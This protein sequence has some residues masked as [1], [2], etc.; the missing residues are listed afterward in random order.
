MVFF[1]ENW[2]QITTLRGEKNVKPPFV[3]NRFQ[4][5][6]LH[7]LCKGNSKISVFPFSPLAKFNQALLWRITELTISQISNTEP[8]HNA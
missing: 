3:D 1:L 4:N 8:F 5:Y 7:S 2:A 6:D